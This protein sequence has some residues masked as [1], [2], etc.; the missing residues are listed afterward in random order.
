MAM[1]ATDAL[2]A[3][4]VVEQQERYE[5]MKKPWHQPF[6]RLPMK[7]AFSILYRYRDLEVLHNI[8]RVDGQSYP[9]PHETVGK[10]GVA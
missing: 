7:A 9:G 2:V 10:V 6:S 8:L 3:D 5:H 4:H 1:N